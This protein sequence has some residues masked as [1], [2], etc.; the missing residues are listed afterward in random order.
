MIGNAPFKEQQVHLKS[1]K[2]LYCVE[3]LMALGGG[4]VAVSSKAAINRA[5]LVLSSS[6]LA[7]HYCKLY[8]LRPKKKNRFQF[9]FHLPISKVRILNGFLQL[10]PSFYS[11]AHNIF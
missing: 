3:Y 2:G 4:V 5:A 8:H 7:R 9:P 11:Y 10:C 6:V 1:V